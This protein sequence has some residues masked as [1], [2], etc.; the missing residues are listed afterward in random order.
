M[1]L[2]HFIF[3]SFLVFSCSTNPQNYNINVIDK[4]PNKWETGIQSS[5]L[6]DDNWWKMFNDT[7]L[8][9]YLNIVQLMKYY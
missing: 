1:K 2:I 4:I 3:F 8:N 7:L 9:N 6:F 5:N